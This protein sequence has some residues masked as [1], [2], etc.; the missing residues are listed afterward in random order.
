VQ[1]WLFF[2]H[3]GSTCYHFDVTDTGRP[4]FP[5][6]PGLSFPGTLSRGPRD[7]SSFLLRALGT[8]VAQKKRSFAE[9]GLRALDLLPLDDEEDDE[10]EALLLRQVYLADIEEGHDKEA[11]M[12]AT[13]MLE[14]GA[15]GDIARQDAARAALGTQNIEAAIEHLQVAATIC[16]PSR[17]AFHYGHLGALLRFSGHAQEA[18][19][20]FKTALRWATE[21]RT[22]YYAQQALT[23]AADG[24]TLADLSSLRKNLELDEPRPGYALWIL[25]ELCVLLGDEV[26]GADY[27]RRFISRQ[28]TAPR[29]KSLALKEEIAHAHALLN[30]ITA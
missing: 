7:A 23:E 27:L 22:L 29:A 1:T 18:I 3:L 24:A 15:L 28:S 26:A 2:G 16:P 12:V 8:K 11:L 21:H 4:T 25:G 14:I 20:A 17:R 6:K 13:E 10:L 5:S 19:D 9:Q 30:Q